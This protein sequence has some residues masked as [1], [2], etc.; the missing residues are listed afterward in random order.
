[1]SLKH[2]AVSDQQ[3]NNDLTPSGARDAHHLGLRVKPPNRIA[4]ESCNET[5]TPTVFAAT[6]SPSTQQ[7]IAEGFQPVVMQ[8]SAN[9]SS[10]FSPGSHSDEQAVVQASPP[11]PAAEQ[12]PPVSPTAEGFIHVGSQPSMKS[13]EGSGDSGVEQEAADDASPPLRSIRN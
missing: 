13:K 1:M 8:S 7:G 4:A 12:A 3:S 10:M 6:L 2:G 5:P 11:H 9:P